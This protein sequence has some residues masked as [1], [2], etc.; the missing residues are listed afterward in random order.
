[1]GPEHG[2]GG[3]EMMRGEPGKGALALQGRQEGLG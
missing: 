2:Q 3:A 1:M